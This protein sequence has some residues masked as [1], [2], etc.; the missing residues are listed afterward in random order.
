MAMEFGSSR[1]QPS[2]VSDGHHSVS[3]TKSLATDTA[4]SGIKALASQPADYRISGHHVDPHIAL[5]SGETTPEVYAQERL[6]FYQE[7]E[8]SA[9]EDRGETDSSDPFSHLG[10]PI[11]VIGETP[12]E[13]MQ[14]LENTVS[15]LSRFNDLESDDPVTFVANQPD[16][17]CG[18]CI[19]GVHCTTRGAENDTVGD[20]MIALNA[21]KLT[22]ERLGLSDA[23][24]V[25]TEIIKFTDDDPEPAEVIRTNAAT[26]REVL[27]HPLFM[28]Y[29]GILYNRWFIEQIDNRDD[30]GT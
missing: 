20:D 27:T 22:T 14:Y 13:N 9:R 25:D 16:A 6:A 4:Q 21:F 15:V 1:I 29:Q 2:D 18:T 30:L 10:N 28:E 24:T 5:A 12:E 8:R 23:V 3:S 17:I 7:L 19:H 11:D 26:A